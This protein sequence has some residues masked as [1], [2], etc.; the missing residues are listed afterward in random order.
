[1]K[2]NQ[3]EPGTQSWKKIF[4]Q[5]IFKSNPEKAGIFLVGSQKKLPHPVGGVFLCNKLKT[6]FGCN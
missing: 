1:L 2:K 4:T 6:T 5:T 3:T